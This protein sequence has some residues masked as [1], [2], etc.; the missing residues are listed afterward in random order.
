[1][2]TMTLHRCGTGP[3]LLCEVFS[4][5]IMIY[6]TNC[7][8]NGR[9]NIS[10]TYYN[11]KPKGNEIAKI[12]FN[13]MTV[14]NDMLSSF[15]TNGYCYCP[16][17]RKKDNVRESDYICIDV[18]DSTVPMNEYVSTLTDK[19]TIYYTTPSNGCI[20]KSQQKYG[21]DKHIYRF[22]LLYA[23]DTPTT[24][25]TE[26]LQAFRYIVDTNNMSFV[27]F[28]PA[29]QYYNGSKGCELHNTHRVYTLPDQ[30]KDVDV[31]H[32]PKQSTPKPTHKKSRAGAEPGKCIKDMLDK[33]VLQEFLSCTRYE[34]FLSWCYGEFGESSLLRET[35]Y[36]QDENDER[37]LIPDDYYVIPKKTIGWD[38]ENKTDI[39]G[40]WHDGEN[41]HTKI[42]TTGIILRRLNPEASVNDL[43]REVVSILLTYYS[44]KNSNGSV[45]FT[46]DYILQ[47]LDSVMKAD[48]GVEMKG[49]KHPAFKISD[50]YC[51]KNKVSKRTVVSEILSEQRKERKEERYCDID[52]FYDPTIRWDN[53]KKITQEQWIAILKENGIEVSIA[54]FKRYL[55][56]RGYSKKRNHRKVSSPTPIYN[57]YSIRFGNDTF[58]DETDG[59]NEHLS[60]SNRKFM[61]I[62]EGIHESDE[63]RAEWR[64]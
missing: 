26:Y 15:I 40:K 25:A 56:E 47:L 14:S 9:M 3:T 64:L 34:D 48:L 23:L 33:D 41:R 27:D 54:T 12:K 62:V 45:K 30:Y 49:V 11:E 16:T 42:Y 36:L 50:A 13:E 24:N 8:F 53:G 32:R 63:F 2:I 44:L 39:Y 19:P 6:T 51:N 7:N 1:M 22:R 57:N 58:L 37:K 28:R 35:P 43:L 61:E 10:S 21:D 18:D 52:Y 59:S 29:N 4:F 20:E 55:G 5:L 38:K 31:G 17:D 60:S 46:K